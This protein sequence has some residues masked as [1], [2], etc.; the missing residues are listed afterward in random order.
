MEN[1]FAGHRARL[2]REFIENGGAGMKDRELLELLLT[3]AIP[4]ADVSPRARALL[5][6]F[7]SLD[8]VVHAAPE[9][10][11][12]VDGIGESAAVFLNT[13]GAATQRIALRAYQPEE[14]AARIATAEEAAGLALALFMEDTYEC[15]RAVCLD[16][17]QRILSVRVIS[18]GDLSS[19]AG[20]PRKIMEQALV[21]KASSLLLM[22]NHPSGSALPSEADKRTADRLSALGAELSV[23]VL[24]QL[25]VGKGAVY[26]F[27][28]GC[29]FVFSGQ[30]E[31]RSVSPEEYARNAAD[32]A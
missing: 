20:D 28:Y 19:V 27:R 30:N 13:V 10:L 14:G 8:K 29:V 5:E 31:C 2:R 18:G 17:R 23:N 26:S 9:R 1:R 32:R 24:D 21:Q 11:M 16:S 25:V 7:G 6:T 12:T 3:Y 15:L 22:H 4:R